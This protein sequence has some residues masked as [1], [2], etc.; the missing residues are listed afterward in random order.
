[1]LCRRVL[2]VVLL[3]VPFALLPSGV[4]AA[5]SPFGPWRPVVDEGCIP[6]PFRPATWS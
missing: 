3:L 6:S 1:M 4:A 5:V 2:A